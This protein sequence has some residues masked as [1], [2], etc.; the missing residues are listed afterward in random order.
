[1][2]TQL[3]AYFSHVHL[4]IAPAY[5]DKPLPSDRMADARKVVSD[6][7]AEHWEQAR[8]SLSKGEFHEI[9]YSFAGRSVDLVV[10][11]DCVHQSLNTG[12]PGTR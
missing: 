1:M 5:P 9:A 2:V 12:S 6:H 7:F 4:H 3:A 10:F 8:F 11:D